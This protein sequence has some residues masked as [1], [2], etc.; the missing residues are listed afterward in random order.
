M[1]ADNHPLLFIQMKS[2][3]VDRVV[4]GRSGATVLVVLGALALMG[5]LTAMGA[6]DPT[7]LA[8]IVSALLRF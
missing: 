4:I 7:D 5:L 6:L 3:P 1:A 8:R 2:G